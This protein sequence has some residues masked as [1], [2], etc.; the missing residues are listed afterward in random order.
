M[1]RILHSARKVILGCAVV[2]GLLLL[3]IQQARSHSGGCSTNKVSD[4]FFTQTGN[5]NTFSSTS[6]GAFQAQVN[7]SNYSS[8]TPLTIGNP[9]TIIPSGLQRSKVSI[10]Y[11]VTLDNGTTIFDGDELTLQAANF[12]YTQSLPSS[13]IVFVN[14]RVQEQSGVK[15]DTTQYSL[16]LDISC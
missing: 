15:T 12:V 6:T 14:V 2:S 3:P 1:V 4:G 13:F 9:V 10:T 5:G 11:T 7:V 16:S 8:L